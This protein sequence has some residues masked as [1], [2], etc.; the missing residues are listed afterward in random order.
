MLCEPRDQ[1]RV[2][3]RGLVLVVWT[4]AEGG[5]D[6]ICSAAKFDEVAVYVGDCTAALGQDAITDLFA[7]D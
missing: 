5:A 1:V 4:Q 6:F 7:T 3:F 2:E